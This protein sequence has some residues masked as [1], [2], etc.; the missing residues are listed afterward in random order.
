[1]AVA[2]FTS[3]VDTTEQTVLATACMVTSVLIKANKN[4]SAEA[5]LSLYNNATPTPGTTEP[6]VVLPIDTL[7]KSGKGMFKFIFPGGIAFD[8]ACTVFVSQTSPI[9]ATAAATTVAPEE[10]LVFYQPG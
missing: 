5:W 6:D 9:D 7:A 4:Q 3:F 8:T 1:M 10:I 2:R